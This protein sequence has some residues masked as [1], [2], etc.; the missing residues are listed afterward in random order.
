MSSTN[1]RRFTYVDRF[2]QINF[3]LATGCLWVVACFILTNHLSYKRFQMKVK[4]ENVSSIT[5]EIKK[6]IYK[7]REISEGLE[8]ECNGKIIFSTAKTDE[9]DR[10]S[11]MLAKILKGI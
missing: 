1:L 9:S 6:D 10:R 11:E 5:I 7:I 3:I 8:V 4:H 2:F